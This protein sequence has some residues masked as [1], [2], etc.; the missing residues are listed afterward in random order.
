[1]KKLLASLLF[2]CCAGFVQVKAQHTDKKQIAQRITDTMTVRLS[3]SNEQI[4]KVLTI[5]ETFTGQA[6]VIK[7]EGDGKLAKLKKLKAIDKERDESLKG[8]LTGAQFKKYLEQKKENRE[9][10]KQRFKE[11]KKE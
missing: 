1:M 10:A 7:G 3:L 2:L 5:N 6:A 9:E 8:V 4:P 11:M